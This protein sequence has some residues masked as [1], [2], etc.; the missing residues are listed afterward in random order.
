MYFLYYTFIA[1]VYTFYLQKMFAVKQL[2]PQQPH[3]SRVY[4]ISLLH[5]FLL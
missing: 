2:G 4:L 5:C 1:R 3:T